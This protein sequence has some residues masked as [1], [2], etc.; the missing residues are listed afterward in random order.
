MAPV[1]TIRRAGA[2]HLDF[3]QLRS[4]SV[5]LSTFHDWPLSAGFIV[6]P[7][8]LAVAG[9]FYTGHADRVQCAFCRGC[10]CNWKPGDV[11]AHEHRRH[12]PDCSLMRGAVAVA[13]RRAP[14]STTSARLRTVSVL[15]ICIL[16]TKVSYISYR[17]ITSLTYVIWLLYVPKLGFRSFVH[18]FANTDFAAQRRERILRLSSSAELRVSY[19]Q[20]S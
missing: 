13:D 17:L 15:S 3:V 20:M 5:R 19:D 1:Q 6:E 16:V 14:V 12:F 18:R 9:F 7:R 10:L 11:P 4:E 8:D 2:N